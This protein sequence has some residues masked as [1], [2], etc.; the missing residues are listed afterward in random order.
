MELSGKML[1]YKVYLAAK[2][3]EL[4]YFFEQLVSVQGIVVEKCESIENSDL[5]ISYNDEV[6]TQLPVVYIPKGLKDSTL[7]TLSFESINGNVRLTDDIVAGFNYWLSHHGEKGSISYGNY[8][9]EE[10]FQKHS[11]SF[12]FPLLNQALVLFENAILHSIGENNYLLTRSRHPFKK[13]FSLVLSHDIDYLDKRFINRLKM[14]RNVLKLVSGNSL[15]KANWWE[16]FRF[17]VNLRPLSFNILEKIE[18]A[19]GTS[20]VLNFC[21][22][23]KHSE[24]S[25]KDVL[26][27]PAYTI[28]DADLE[29]LSQFFEIGI[30]G[31]TKVINN[32]ERFEQELGSIRS[33]TRCV[34]TRQHM[35][36]FHFDNTF[37]IQEMNGILYDTSIGFNDFN[38]Y[39]AN[40]AFPYHPIGLDKKRFG[41]VEYPLVFMD[42][43][44]TKQGI[45][46]SKPIIQSGL[47]L[48]D[49]AVKLGNF[50]G[51]VCWHDSAFY[52]GSTLAKS[53]ND[54]L[55]LFKQAG[56][57]LGS[58]LDLYDFYNSVSTLSVKHGRMLIV[59]DE[60]D[61]GVDIFRTSCLGIEKLG[62]LNGERTFKLN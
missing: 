5:V 34:G 4:D 18:S 15:A 24:D 40:A 47:E 23:E 49:L 62:E 3:F 14:L 8:K 58:P 52:K 51:S 43:V 28:G 13:E 30:H 56:G 7:A 41:V 17:I 33:R 21:G 57:F 26:L 35:L 55:S 38:G 1:V 32:L 12:N 2:T 59:D 11:F 31:S 50:S 20:S 45:F 19:H 39:R 61:G 44:F 53:Y 46:K 60:I 37:S 25:A 42:S 29:Q 10:Y 54:V 16:L 6:D 9:D 48:I 22:F 27:N 36:S